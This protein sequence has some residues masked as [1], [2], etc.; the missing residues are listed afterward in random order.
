VT[1]HRGALRDVRRDRGLSMRAAFP[2]Y[3]GKARLAGQIAALLPAHCVYVEPFCGSAAVLFA[4]PASGHEILNDRDGNVVTFFRVLREQ[5]EA[6]QRACQLS[7]YAR[8]EY[9]ACDLRE[10]VGDLERA[11]RFFVA[12][13]QSYNANGTFP[14][15]SSW[16]TSLRQGGSK[17]AAARRRA[18]ALHLCAERLRSVIVENR[19]ALEVLAAFDT[20]QTTFYVDPPYLGSVRDSLSTGRRRRD[21]SHDMTSHADHALLAVA[22]HA[23]RGTVLLSGYSSDLYDALYAGWDRLDITVPRPASNRFGVASDRVREVIWSN[24]PLAAQLALLAA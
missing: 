20:P 12:A 4:K 3:G 19:P 5:P 7:P 8:D 16:V 18:D 23:C 2:Y 10:E 9:E 14:G 6:L 1:Q 22:L 11:R 17:A 21:Y 24:R 15:R 13:T